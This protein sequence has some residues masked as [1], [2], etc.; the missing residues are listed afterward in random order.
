M[1]VEQL[2]KLRAFD[3]A[4]ILDQIEELLTV[5]PTLESKA[6]VKQLRQ[7]APTQY[8]LRAGDY[9]IL[10]TPRLFEPVSLELSETEIVGLKIS[11]EYRKQRWK[12]ALRG[13]RGPISSSRRAG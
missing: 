9:R 4:A 3:R 10:L 1:A 6:R 2:K 5:N 11:P 8:R 13:G 12:R 7:P